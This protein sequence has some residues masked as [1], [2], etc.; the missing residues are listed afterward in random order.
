MIINFLSRR[1]KLIAWS[2]YFLFYGDW[3]IAAE[4]NRPHATRS[5]E[6]GAEVPA[7]QEPDSLYPI[8]G[9]SD[10]R[11]ELRRTALRIRQED[12]SRPFLAAR[13]EG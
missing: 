1:S 13:E 12:R 10:G 2:F 8:P 7:Y 4:L 6:A 9:L 11:T 3:L 5:Y